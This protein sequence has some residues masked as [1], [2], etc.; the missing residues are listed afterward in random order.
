MYITVSTGVGGGWIL[1][2]RPWHGRGMAGEIGHM[3]VDPAGPLCL[4]GKRMCRATGFGTVHAQQV[5]ECLQHSPER[6][7]IAYSGWRQL[8]AVR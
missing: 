4:C 7:S 6:D 3:V 1:N 8:E 2:G 5:R